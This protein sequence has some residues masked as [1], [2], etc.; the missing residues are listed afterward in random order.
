MNMFTYHIMAT[1]M[2]SGETWYKLVWFD[3]KNNFHS[4]LYKNKENAE[5]SA[6]TL[7]ELFEKGIAA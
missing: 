1:K 2:V 4:E 3:C 5:S 6:Q 7:K